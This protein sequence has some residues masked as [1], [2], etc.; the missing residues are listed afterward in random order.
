VKKSISWGFRGNPSLWILA[1]AT[2][3]GPAAASPQ[4][5]T[6]TSATIVVPAAP[7]HQGPKVPTPPP[8]PPGDAWSILDGQP[9]NRQEQ[10]VL[11]RR[12]KDGRQD[13]LSGYREVLVLLGDGRV[14]DAEVALDTFERGSLEGR[15]ARD[16]GRL[17]DSEVEVV[18]WLASRD[19]EA[20]VPLLALHH[21]SFTRY[22][23]GG[24]PFLA[25]HASR[26]SASL[27]DLYA[28][29][30]GT[31]GSRVLGARALATLGIRSQ[32]AGMKNEGPALMLAA[33]AHDPRSEAALLGIAAAHERTG[34]YVK[35]VEHLE[36]LVRVVPD[37]R[38]GRLRLGINLG[39]LGAL[40]RAEKL[41]RGLAREDEDDWI[42]V[43][44][45]EELGRLLHAAGR[46]KDAQKVL[47]AGLSRFP[48][49]GA[50]RTTLVL[51]L[52]SQ[53]LHR[54][55]LAL[56]EELPWVEPDT[57]PSPRLLYTRGPQETF[58]AAEAELAA[59]AT[60]RTRRLGQLVRGTM[61][62][63]GSDGLA[64]KDGGP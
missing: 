55:A 52:D 5:E 7:G 56:M 20:L 50:L 8:P 31:E 12:N 26:I 33:L 38:E 36:N 28:R 60:P 45:V 19:V 4:S 57:G 35:A 27:A 58:T 51:V 17:F 6:T 25:A 42:A 9:A 1:L 2:L 40:E 47:E 62:A 59:S 16:L 63:A 46:T 48:G 43:L 49:E 21:R 11:D 13:L 34:G 41:L 23:E 61:T 54:Q 18:R 15:N 22:V 37:H 29:V 3:V 53:K 10:K 30:G 32:R 24:E 39:R 44:A 64:K 14:G